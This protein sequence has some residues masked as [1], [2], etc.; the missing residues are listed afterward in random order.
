MVRGYRNNCIIVQSVTTKRI[1]ER[2]DTTV[3]IMDN[4]HVISHLLRKLSSTRQL[5]LPIRL[6]I[7]LVRRPCYQL[8]EK[9]RFLH[10]Y[11]FNSPFHQHTI[12]NTCS[13]TQSIDIPVIPVSD[14]Y[15]GLIPIIIPIDRHVY[16]RVIPSLQRFGDRIVIHIVISGSD[17]SAF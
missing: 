17:G 7:R 5:R 15:L 13:T 4:L 12:R 9:R 2:S 14:A 1:D 11:F 3:G 16:R 6:I 10:F 8:I